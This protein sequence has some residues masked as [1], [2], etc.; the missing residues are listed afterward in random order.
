MNTSE[1]TSVTT[2]TCLVPSCSAVFEHPSYVARKYCSHACASKAKSTNPHRKIRPKTKECKRCKDLIEPSFTYCS[3]CWVSKPEWELAD[4]VSMW[5][6]GDA[7]VADGSG[8]QLHAWARTYLLGLA[9]NAC[10]ECGWCTPN[11]ILNRPILT[12]DHIDGDWSNNR[13]D[14][15]K[16]LCYNCHTL[17]DTFGTLNTG[18]KGGRKRSYNRYTDESN[19]TTCVDCG[20]VISV[21]ALRC[22]SHSSAAKGTIDWPDPDRMVFLLEG[23]TFTSVASELGVTDN[24]IRSYLRRKGYDPKTLKQVRVD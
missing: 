1:R 2:S 4:K 24:A 6:A 7:S 23:R 16:V 9:N 10:S 3:D 17:T 20:T 18:S 21:G 15:L 5:V 11:P 19:K 12:I 14:N 13:F 22:R 8:H